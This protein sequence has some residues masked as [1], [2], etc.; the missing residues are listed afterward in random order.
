MGAIVRTELLHEVPDVEVD[1]GLGDAEP[2]GDLLVAMP[3]PDE[4]QDVELAPREVLVGVVRREPRRDVGRDGAPTGRRVHGTHGREQLVGRRGLQDI[5]GGAGAQR[6][7]DLAITFDGR[8]HDDSRVGELPQDGRQRVD[9]VRSRETHVH[10]R[11]VRAS[12]PERE[13]RVTCGGGLGHEAHVGLG[14]D[15]RAE[16]FAEDGVVFHAQDRDRLRWCAGR[17]HGESAGR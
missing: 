15:D 8:E 14:V 17:A 4:A 2:V 9:A 16:A 5:A 10:Q 7:P 1:R 12:L 6:P 11:D 13:Q 3:V